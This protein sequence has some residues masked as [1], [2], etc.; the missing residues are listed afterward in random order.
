MG[1]KY[2]TG[3]CIFQLKVV[4]NLK[5]EVPYWEEVPHVGGYLTGGYLTRVVP[6][7]GIRGYFIWGSRKY[8]IWGVTHLGEGTARGGYLTWG[9]RNT[10]PGKV[11]HLGGN[12]PGGSTSRGWGT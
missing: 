1:E 8:F 6:H 3:G 10:S 12:S 5:G 9:G 11:P 4:P 2:F 7:L